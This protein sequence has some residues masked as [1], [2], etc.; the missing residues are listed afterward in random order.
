MTHE[1]SLAAPGVR[2]VGGKLLR[3][4]AR[5]Q[6]LALHVFLDGSLLEVFTGEAGYDA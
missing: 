5:G 4:P 1:F 6:P 2:R 3:P